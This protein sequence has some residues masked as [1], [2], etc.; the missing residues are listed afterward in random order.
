MDNLVLSITHYEMNMNT[1]TQEALGILQEECAE[2]I[3]A[4]SKINRFGQSCINPN[5]GLSNQ[6]ALEREIGDVLYM[7]EYLKRNK[8]LSE[9]NLELAML[10]KES[11]LRCYS[12]LFS[13]E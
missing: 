2:L 12:N 9:H 13:E 3:S 7:I 5:T 6:E 8:F 4:V 1:N 11:N 10:K